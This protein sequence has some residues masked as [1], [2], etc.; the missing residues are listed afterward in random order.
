MKGGHTLGH[1]QGEFVR[2]A[3]MIVGHVNLNGL[4]QLLDIGSKLL[5]IHLEERIFHHDERI[6]ALDNV[7]GIAHHVVSV[8]HKL[9]LVS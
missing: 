8:I 9:L 4:A 3:Q 6:L 7:A 2:A 5:G 1:R